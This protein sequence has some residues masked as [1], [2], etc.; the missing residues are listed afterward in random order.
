MHGDDVIRSLQGG[1]VVRPR[2]DAPSGIQEAKQ[3]SVKTLSY[4]LVMP[5]APQFWEN[6]WRT[7]FLQFR[8]CT[9]SVYWN[10]KYKE[11]HR[12]VHG[13]RCRL[14]LTPVGHCFSISCNKTWRLKW[15]RENYEKLQLTVYPKIIRPSL[16]AVFLRMIR[17]H[18][19]RVTDAFEK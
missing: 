8:R 1:V 19:L 4:G 16:C 12:F 17:K 6:L 15:K 18:S 5:V 11:D 3:K 7:L 9:D 14:S 10:Q 13:W 2:W